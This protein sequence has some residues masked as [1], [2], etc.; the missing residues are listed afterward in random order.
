MSRSAEGKLNQ[1]M[2]SSSLG[3]LALQK[4]AKLKSNM[5]VL[6]LL[7]RISMIR[8][9]VVYLWASASL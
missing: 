1:P 3:K 9:D 6:C 4:W 8:E 2:S 7:T 5:Y